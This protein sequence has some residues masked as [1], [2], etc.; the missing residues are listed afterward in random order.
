MKSF[1]NHPLKRK[2]VLNSNVFI[3]ANGCHENRIDA[4]SLKHFLEC[5]YHVQMVDTLQQADFVVVQGCSVT[6][7]MENETK[8]IVKHVKGVKDSQSVVVTGCFSKFRSEWVAGQ[9]D[10]LLPMSEIDN[11]LYRMGSYAK[12][13]AANRLYENP[14]QIESFLKGNKESTIHDSFGFF[15][16]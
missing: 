15:K 2:N 1:K 3:V 10:S 5:E 7:H 9:N 4:A 11:N 16:G 12:K 8:A 14:D 6:Q 13:H